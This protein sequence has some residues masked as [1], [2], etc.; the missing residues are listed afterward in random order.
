ML[1]VSFL[2]FE[3]IV[4]RHYI[5]KIIVSDSFNAKRFKMIYSVS[6]NIVNYGIDYDYFARINYSKRV[7]EKK[8]G[9]N[10]I[11]LQVGVFTIYKNQLASLKTIKNLKDKIS[12]FNLILAGHWDDK[13][14]KS[15]IDNYIHKNDLEKFVVLTGHLD[16]NELRSYYH[17]CDVLIHPIRSQGGWLTPFEAISAGKPVIVS[18]KMTAAEIIKKEEIGIVTEDYVNAV[19]YVYKNHEYCHEMILRGKNWVNCNL[20]WDNFGAGLLKIFLQS[21]R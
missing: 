14:Y 9:D 3:K 13:S 19:M 12:D 5:D 11:I 18:P 15:K 10:F 16:R 7:S 21:L 17:A 20:T 8:R 1:K 6:S 2:F 4:V